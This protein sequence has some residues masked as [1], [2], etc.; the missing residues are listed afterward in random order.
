M[1]MPGRK[2]ARPE[3]RSAHPEV[4]KQPEEV[5]QLMDDQHEMFIQRAKDLDAAANQ[6]MVAAKARDVSTYETTLV[7]I[8]EACENCH[9]HFWYP[10]DVRA[11][12]LAANALQ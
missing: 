2:S 8:D 10:D 12:A 11:R 3:D 6:A 9:I 4:E 5:Q 1:V 7:E